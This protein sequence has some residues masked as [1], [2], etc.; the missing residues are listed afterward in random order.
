[1]IIKYLSIIR[2][3]LHLILIGITIVERPGEGPTKK[4]EAIQLIQNLAGD[5]L[6]NWIIRIL[7]NETTLG[8][9]IDYIV[10]RLNK[11]EIFIHSKE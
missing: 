10:N 6:P 8:I 11:E 3:V 1:M 2:D 4:K 5:F 9:L 7:L